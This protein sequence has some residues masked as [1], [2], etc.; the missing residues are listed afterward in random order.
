MG[1]LGLDDLYGP[2]QPKPACDTVIYILRGVTT[3]SAIQVV[4]NHYPKKGYKK[5]IFCQMLQF[6]L[7][8]TFCSFSDFSFLAPSLS[9]LLL[10]R[11]K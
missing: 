2:S 8:Y 7:K 10:V 3:T 1:E 4:N 9:H 6:F 11:Q 5:E